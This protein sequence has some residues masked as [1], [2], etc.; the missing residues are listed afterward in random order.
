MK[1]GLKINQDKTK[2]M[3]ALRKWKD[4]HVEDRLSIK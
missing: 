4:L 3:H 2:C 1:R